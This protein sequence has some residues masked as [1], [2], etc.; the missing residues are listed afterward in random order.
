M[1]MY[2]S[3]CVLVYTYASLQ[4]SNNTHLWW[5]MVET[6]I[7]KTWY[8]YTKRIVTALVGDVSLYSQSVVTARA[9][10]LP[11][12]ISNDMHLWWCLVESW[13]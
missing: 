10:M 7:K 12:Q 4:I 3:V 1:Y 2:V 5:C 13:K 8:Q 11:L 6:V 9:F